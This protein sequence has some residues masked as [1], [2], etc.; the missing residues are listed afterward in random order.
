M[1]HESLQSHT[2]LLRYFNF[3]ITVLMRLS[4]HSLASSL[5]IL[6]TSSDD[7]AMDFA[8]AIRSFLLPESSWTSWES[9]AMR[10]AIFLAAAMMSLSLLDH[11]FTSWWRSW[12]AI[13][14]Q[15]EKVDVFVIAVCL[16]LLSS[17][18][19]DGSLAGRGSFVKYFLRLIVSGVRSSSVSP[20]PSSKTAAGHAATRSTRNPIICRLRWPRRWV[21][22]NG[23]TYSYSY[24]S[25]KSKYHWQ[26]LWNG[27]LR[28][29]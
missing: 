15:K 1:A 4:V 10:R 13:C 2:T 11:C 18:Y 26:T 20:S 23:P 19:H 28:S 22:W 9:R 24:I 7:S 6:V 17:T 25:H 12:A 3:L 29:N 16:D 8:Q 27:Q 21:A 14:W 5:A